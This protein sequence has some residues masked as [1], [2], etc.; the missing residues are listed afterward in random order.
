MNNSAYNQCYNCKNLIRY[1]TKGIKQF[2]K[3]DLGW[4]VEKQ[5][6]VN[7]KNQCINF[8]ATPKHKIR[9]RSINR[10]LNDLLTEITEIRK[11][12]EA[13]YISNEEM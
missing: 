8:I 4:C 2:N 6:H 1:Y 10:Y 7:V 11:V 5:E 12:I 13:E 9:K 3:S